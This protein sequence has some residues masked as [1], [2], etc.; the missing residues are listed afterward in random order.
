MSLSRRSIP[1][2]NLRVD[3]V[4]DDLLRPNPWNPNRQD[5]FIFERE[6]ASIQRFGFVDPILVRKLDD[7]FEI[8]D[9]EHRLRACRQLGITE[10]PIIDL[11]DVDDD[12][13]KQ[14]T[15]VLN[16]TRGRAQPDLLRSLISDL[17]KRH[18][19]EELLAVL[20]YTPEQFEAF[21]RP[22]DWKDVEERKPMAVETDWVLR[23]YR[24]PK[25]AAEVLDEAIRRVQQD[26]S[27]PDWRAI[28]LIAADFIS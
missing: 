14:L 4:S 1:T 16:E 3:Y 27:V 18:P 13:A 12:D 7:W 23:S 28:E 17:A 15:I 10:I 2:T 22:F 19:V 25:A 21:R 9:G 24:L 11:G 20:P 26:E 6:L 5:D 8:I